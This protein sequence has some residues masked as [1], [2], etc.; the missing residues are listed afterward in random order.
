MVQLSVKAR[1]PIVARVAAQ[2]A[3]GG[4]IAAFEA[5]IRCLQLQIIVKVLKNR[6]DIM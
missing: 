5:L 4:V 2:L 6:L 3:V 1:R